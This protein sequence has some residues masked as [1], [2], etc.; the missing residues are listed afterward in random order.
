MKI[1]V[2]GATGLVG[3]QFIKDAT[4]QDFQ[5]NFLT[6]KRIKTYEE[7]NIK[8]FYWNPEID[9]IEDLSCFDDG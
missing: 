9:L 8:G 5:I 4:A 3:T 2:T 6:T 1:L 7:R